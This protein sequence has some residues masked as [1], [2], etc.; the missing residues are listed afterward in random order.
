MLQTRWIW[1]GLPRVCRANENG[2]SGMTGLGTDHATSQCNL[3]Q[4]DQGPPQLTVAA[5]L[6]QKHQTATTVSKT[7]NDFADQLQ[8]LEQ[9]YQELLALPL[10]V[11]RA[12]RIS[13]ERVTVGQTPK[14]NSFNWR[15]PNRGRRSK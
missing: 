7:P 6:F 14:T 11:R 4:E 3:P 1:C 8:D 13:V 12:E 2:S 15:K 9:L 10:R 5:G